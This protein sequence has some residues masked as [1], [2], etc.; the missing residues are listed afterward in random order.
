MPWHIETD[1]P[2]CSGFAVVQDDNG[3]VMGCHEIEAEAM[4]QMAALYAKEPMM[5]A[6]PLGETRADAPP[7]RLPFPVTRAL[8]SAI[9]CRSEGE[10][11]PTMVGHFSTFGDWY[12]VDSMFEGH[13]LENVGRGAFTKTIAE[14]RSQMKVLYDHGQ[15]PQDRQQ[16]TRP[17][18]GSALTTRS[19]RLT[20][21]RSSTPRPT[22]ICGRDS[23]RASIGSSFRFTVEKDQWDHAP[24]RSSRNPDGIPE[25]TITEARVFEFGPGDV[26]GQSCRDGRRSLHYRQLLPPEPRS[27]AVWRTPAIRPTRPHSARP[28]RGSREPAPRAACRHS[29]GAGRAGHSTGSTSR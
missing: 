3:D 12:E 1:N 28:R 21:C 10:G 25:R 13:F 16:G 23:R 9:E 15:D 27:R 8:A 11:M 18:R 5:S 26:P 22:A 14:G 29:R 20:P 6:K 19:G 17:D 2:D 7:A 24:E 4:A